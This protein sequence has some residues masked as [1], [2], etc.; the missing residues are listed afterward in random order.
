MILAKLKEIN[1][2]KDISPNPV[3]PHPTTFPFL[4][5]L[6]PKFYLKKKRQSKLRKYHWHDRRNQIAPF[7]VQ[8]KAL[9]W[10]VDNDKTVIKST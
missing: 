3:V 1:L 10:K 7:L 2:K 9:L 5:I 6:R 8:S 4:S